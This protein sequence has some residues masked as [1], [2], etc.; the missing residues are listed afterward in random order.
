MGRRKIEI[1]AIKDDRNRSVTFLKRKGGLFKKA[2]ELSVLCSVDVAV[3][4]FGNNKKLYEYSSSDL[5][6]ILTRYQYYGGAN[7]H[8]GPADFNGKDKLDYDDDDDDASV[9]SH[10]GSVEPQMMPP[11]FQ[12]QVAYQHIRRHT[13]SASPPVPSMTLFAHQSK[14]QHTPQPQLPDKRPSSRNAGTR[15]SSNLAPQRSQP[16]NGYAYMANP[17]I[18]NSQS[19]SIPSSHPHNLPS[20]LQASSIQGPPMQQGHALQGSQYPN[21]QP[22]P[23]QQL[24]PHQQHLRHTYQEDRQKAEAP[25]H[26]ERQPS[27]SGSTPPQPP[28]QALECPPPPPEVE[29][30]QEPQLPQQILEPVKRISVKSRSIFTP[31][32]ESRS[33]LSQHWASSTSKV[34]ATRN[35]IAISA[36]RLQ[37]VEIN[38]NN[39]PNYPSSPGCTPSHTSKG[40]G[41]ISAPN[42]SSGQSR[43][44]STSQ[45]SIKRP[46][47]KVQIPDEPSDEGSATAESISSPN[48]T[49]ATPSNSHHN[50][51][52]TD[53]LSS[54]LVLPPPS[55]SAG[56]LISAGATGPPN[57]FAR[58]TVAQNLQNNI[59]SSNINGSICNSNSNNNT[60][61][62]NSN[63]S[64]TNGN[65][66]SSNSIVS[67]NSN[68]N[69]NNNV[70]SNTLSN[71]TNNSN[72]VINGI[73]HSVETP[74]SA[75]PSRFI[76][77]DFLPS[78]SSFYPEWNFRGG[79]GNTL[80]SPLNFATPV[81]GSGPSFM[82]ED[83]TSKESA[84]EN[85]AK[86]NVPECE[87]DVKDK[88][89]LKKG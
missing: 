36:S 84:K 76:T 10:H 62:N 58:P 56:S 44:N 18:Y 29:I 87:A 4:I 24:H 55:P 13:P 5:G 57:P 20:H 88:K 38:N 51:N 19:V 31:I 30:K 2:H 49:N 3:I 72:G 37:S 48:G 12:N 7:E 23:H 69:I 14:R 70:T 43:T 33:I 11:Q 74:I 68:S 89:R 73:N 35:E 83:Q 60:V 42:N 25:T 8:K 26:Q 17:S 81:L 39:P 46:V 32:D 1:K 52:T 47:L 71:N 63:N 78:P 50:G 15:P 79:D 54:G 16:P 86:R 64:S 66:N 21:Y 9:P 22:P 6:E 41:S 65:N 53:S 75:L 67:N 40:H 80:P 82:R 85:H 34:E 59:N 28:Q 77:N 61:V 27:R 45:G